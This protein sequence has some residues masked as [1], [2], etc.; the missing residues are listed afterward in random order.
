MKK[1]FFSGL[2]VGVALLLSS[3]LPAQS[4]THQSQI[5]DYDISP[6]QED[7]EDC[8]LLSA[9][10]SRLSDDSERRIAFFQ[11]KV[12]RLVESGDPG[13]AWSWEGEGQSVQIRFKK[14][15]SYSISLKGLNESRKSIETLSGRFDV[16]TIEQVTDENND[17]VID[18][19]EIISAL[20]LWTKGS[21]VPKLSHTTIDDA[22]M[23]RL[24]T[25]WIKGPSLT[26]DQTLILEFDVD[27]LTL[28]AVSSA[29]ISI[30]VG[31]TAQGPILYMIDCAVGLGAEFN[32][33]ASGDDP[34]Y[35]SECPYLEPGSYTI[36]V[37]VL[38][39]GLKK[40]AVK[41]IEVLSPPPPPRLEL[42]GHLIPTRGMAPLEVSAL[43]LLLGN[44]QGL[45]SVQVD[46]NNDSIWE[47][48][49]SLNPNVDVWD[50]K[51]LCRYERPGNY[52]LLL[53]AE[54]QGAVAFL[55]GEIEV[56]SKD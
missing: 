38:R 41:T 18:D 11:W 4:Q 27:P 25:L 20:H 44:A 51:N 34:F 43:V 45:T 30:R 40:E 49:V 39:A 6:C 56:F 15:T 1:L 13:P 50:V 14:G 47:A 55:R 22:T 12:I 21:E 32:I 35:V 53:K 42:Q 23:L 8:Y 33:I 54:R 9:V 7:I 24:L 48:R 28:E 29:L 16:P 19:L 10:I 5:L 31:G 37:R 26:P 3:S 52:A 36:K 17:G 2:L 46:C